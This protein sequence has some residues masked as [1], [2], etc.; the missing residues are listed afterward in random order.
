MLGLVLICC[1]KKSLEILGRGEEGTRKCA[2]LFLRSVLT[3]RTPVE[4]WRR[5]EQYW[6]HI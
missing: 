6:L 3:G 4:L 1:N 2:S 5:A